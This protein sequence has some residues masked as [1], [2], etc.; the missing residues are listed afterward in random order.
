MLLRRILTASPAAALVVGVVTACSSVP[1]ITFTDAPADGGDASSDARTDG[2]SDASVD[3]SCV[4]SGPENCEDGLDNDC[5]GL[6]DCADPACQPTHQCVDPAPVGWDLV[7]FSPNTR[8]AC[9]T[10]YGA[11]NDIKNV[12]GTGSGTCSCTCTPDVGT[13]CGN[14]GVT[15]SDTA[16]TCGGTTTTRS[17]PPNTN[18]TAI[19]GGNV[20]VPPGQ[21]FGQ[22]TLPAKPTNC[23]SST[24]LAGGTIGQGRACASPPTKGAGCQ[25]SQVCVRKPTGFG[26]C[27]SKPGQ[28]ACPLVYTQQRSAG[29]DLSTD[30][31][32]CNTCTCGTTNCTGTVTLFEAA[33]CSTGMGNDSTGTLTTTCDATAAKNFTA[34]R[35]KTAGTTN[36]C[37][38]ATFNNAMTGAIT[39]DQQRTVCCKP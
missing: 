28:N 21:A 18:C 32:S 8:P 2:P 33:D 15:I 6:V 5:N 26:L 3:P 1:D 22:I 29:S 39:W 30:N 23:A 7:A 38:I 20:D 27:V 35:Y 10:G 9:P 24:T 13:A 37:A 36:G 17:V 4:K 14:I 11:A 31:R 16:T 19:P 12:L 25:G 34:T